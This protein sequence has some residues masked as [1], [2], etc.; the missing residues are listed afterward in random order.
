MKKAQNSAQI[1]ITR[2]QLTKLKLKAIRAGVWFKAL[3]RIDRVLVDLTIQVAVSI[4]STQ[5]AKSVIEVVGK[6]DSL[7]E[8]KFERLAQTIGRSLAQKNSRIAQQWGNMSAKYWS[9]DGSFALY[10]AVMHANK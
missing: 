5:L 10:L 2:N 8:S 6:L 7:L 1:A 3:P 4:R 9:T